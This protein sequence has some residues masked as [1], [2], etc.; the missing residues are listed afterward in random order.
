MLDF[1]TVSQGNRHRSNH[2]QNEVPSIVAVHQS[3]QSGCK[4]PDS[5]MFPITVWHIQASA[6]TN[7]LFSQLVLTRLPLQ[8]LLFGLWCFHDACS[9]S[10]RRYVSWEELSQPLLLFTK[11]SGLGCHSRQEWHSWSH[12]LHYSFWQEMLIRF[13]SEITEEHFTVHPSSVRL[14]NDSSFCTIVKKNIYVY[15]SSAGLWRSW[16]QKWLSHSLTLLSY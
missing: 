3:L 8:D 4:G 10:S 11:G 16:N 1:E 12:R 5:G 2:T 6:W 9:S 7:S 15:D 13:S 14:I